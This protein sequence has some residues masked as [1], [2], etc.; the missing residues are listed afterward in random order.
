M[1][2]QVKFVADEYVQRMFEGA[3]Q[4]LS[5]EVHRDELRLPVHVTKAR[6]RAQVPIN[7]RGVDDADGSGRQQGRGGVFYSLKI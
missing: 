6:H 2:L 7:D 5:Q 1:P 3:R 4:D